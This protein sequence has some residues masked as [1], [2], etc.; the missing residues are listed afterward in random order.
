[1]KYSYCNVSLR[2]VF[3]WEGKRGFFFNKREMFSIR[4]EDSNVLTIWV[5]IKK[6]LNDYQSIRYSK[7]KKGS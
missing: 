5:G 4:D 6:F 3:L 2:G 1:M 7:Y